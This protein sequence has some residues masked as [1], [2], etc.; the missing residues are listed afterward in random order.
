MEPQFR[1]RLGKN[2]G[3]TR[4]RKMSFFAALE[5]I[6]LHQELRLAA[7]E[8]ERESDIDDPDLI[9]SSDPE[10]EEAQDNYLGDTGGGAEGFRERSSSTPNPSHL[11]LIDKSSRPRIAMPMPEMTEMTDPEI[12]STMPTM[13]SHIETAKVDFK[14]KRRLPSNSPKQTV[15]RRFSSGSKGSKASVASYS[16]RKTIGK[17]HLNKSRHGNRHGAGDSGSVSSTGK[18]K[19]RKYHTLNPK[20]LRVD[21]PM[22]LRVKTKQTHSAS[23]SPPPSRSKPSTARPKTASSRPRA[24]TPS[25][26]EDKKFAKDVNLKPNLKATSSSRRLSDPISSIGRG[27][28]RPT[29]SRFDHGGIYKK[30]VG[31]TKVDSKTKKKKKKKLGLGGYKPQKYGTLKAALKKHN[32]RNRKKKLSAQSA[33][34]KPGVAVVTGVENSG[35][36]AIARALAAK[37]IT[38][39]AVSTPEGIE[40]ALNKIVDEEKEHSNKNTLR[41]EAKKIQNAIASTAGSGFGLDPDRPVTPMDEGEKQVGVAAHL[42]NMHPCPADV[43]TKEGCTEVYNMIS[44]FIKTTNKPFRYLV[45]AMA[46]EVPPPEGSGSGSG[47]VGQASG[48]ACKVLDTDEKKLLSI[49]TS[50]ITA[51]IMLTAKLA[52]LFDK[53]STDANRVMVFVKE[54]PRSS[55]AFIDNGIYSVG[56]AALRATLTLLRGELPS[57]DPT[58]HITCVKPVVFKAFDY[59]KVEPRKKRGSAILSSPPP[60]SIDPVVFGAYVTWV[61]MESNLSTFK[62]EGDVFDKVHHRHWAT[63]F[64]KKQML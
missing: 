36:L 3:Q 59:T 40:A 10:P 12:T 29:R 1:N 64:K 24:T 34:L 38:V 22:Q 32:P 51:P 15:G 52:T 25:P 62:Q 45:H 48:S 35:G 33:Q 47:S 28:P 21:S 31:Y 58:I 9:S 4:V 44:D 57:H 6:E 8:A 26:K 7:L 19:I 20:S 11:P 5:N 17:G 27:P 16:S 61:L 13:P 18:K 41:L 54:K 14:T 2:F 46:C 37:D 39:I 49:Q 60:T 63:T 42:D 30:P 43:T 55:K 23:A 53:K 50:M 56:E